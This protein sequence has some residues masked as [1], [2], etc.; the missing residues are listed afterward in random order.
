M[1]SSAG[2]RR[3]KIVRLECLGIIQSKCSR[4]LTI[5]LPF[6]HLFSFCVSSHDLF[7][8]E[9][10]QAGDRNQFRSLAFYDL[11]EICTDLKRG[12]DR[13]SQSGGGGGKLSKSIQPHLIYLLSIYIVPSRN[14]TLR[15]GEEIY[16]FSEPN[17]VEQDTV[18]GGE[19]CP[20]Y[21]FP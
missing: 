20:C 6:F 15:A 14:N 4:A 19:R 11:E 10:T 17:S 7:F 9:T 12:M 16:Q 8:G 21:T 1:A 3:P 13:V 18:K 5:A 2:E